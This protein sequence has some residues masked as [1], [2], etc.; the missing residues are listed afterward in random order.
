MGNDIRSSNTAQELADR[1]NMDLRPPVPLSVKERSKYD[2]IIN[3]R[4]AKEWACG[5]D[6]HLAVTLAKTMCELD[7][8]TYLLRKEGTVVTGPKGGLV[9]NPRAGIVNSLRSMVLRYESR[10]HFDVEAGNATD[11]K[12][13]RIAERFAKQREEHAAD[14]PL[15]QRLRPRHEQDDL[16]PRRG[17]PKIVN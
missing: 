12:H 16:I 4:S 1:V 2:D 5:I 11:R 8:E 14:D 6:L 13:A 10:L 15:I 9:A 3:A 7:R 17:K